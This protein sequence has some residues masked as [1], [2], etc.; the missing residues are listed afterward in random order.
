MST[1]KFVDVRPEGLSSMAKY[2]EFFSRKKSLSW[3]VEHHAV[4][5]F[6]IMQGASA[7]KIAPALSEEILSQL[8]VLPTQVRTSQVLDSFFPEEGGWYPRLLLHESIRTVLVQ[9][10]RDL[11][12]RAPAFVV[13]EGK[14]SRVAA[15]VLAEMGISEIYLVGDPGVLEPQRQIL[16]RQQ[17]GIRFHILN[18]E[19]LTLQAVSAGIVI[20]TMDLRDNKSLLTDLSYFNFMK[21]AG[22]ALDL[23]LFPVENLL[24]EE[25]ERAD[26]KVLHPVLVAEAYTRLWFQRI[27]FGDDISNEEIRGIWNEFLKENSSSV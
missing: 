16:S 22:Y 24:L 7:V 19:D 4:F 27:G 17:L 3:I 18:P 10:A 1:L 21:R 20:N 11:D 2:L 23:N 15:G 26:L 13:G 8:R 14:E 12:I 6:E 9:E 5:S 25:A